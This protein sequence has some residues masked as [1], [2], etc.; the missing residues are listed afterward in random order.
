MGRGSCARFCNGVAPGGRAGYARG[1]FAFPFEAS[2]SR[3][4]RMAQRTISS[5]F[6]PRASPGGIGSTDHKGIDFPAD[7]GTPVLA[8][9]DGT[10]RRVVENH[11]T[12][13]TYVEVEH[14]NGYWSRYLHLSRASVAS[15][16][17]VAQGSTVGLSGGQPGA[18]GSGTSTGPHLHLEVWRGQPYAGGTPIDPLP[19]LTLDAARRALPFLAGAAAWWIVTGVV[20]IGALYFLHPAPEE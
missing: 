17:R 15:G 8:I 10:V 5:G 14:G 7:V 6:G 20:L 19:L 1:M 18:Y 3:Y 12:A 11:A 2:I 13:G 4:G 9:G 16:A